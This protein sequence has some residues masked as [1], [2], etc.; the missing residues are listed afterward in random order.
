MGAG[1]VSA[2]LLA[3]MIVYAVIF[4]VGVLYILRLIAGGPESPPQETDEPPGNPL[5]AASR[6][7][8]P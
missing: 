7:G 5:A 3:F 8:A 6:E 2:S 4:T 1:Q